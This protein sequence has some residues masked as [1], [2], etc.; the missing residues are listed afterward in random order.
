MSLTPGGEA[1][2]VLLIQ[3]GST[4][5]TAA[6]VAFSVPTPGAAS[7]NNGATDTFAPEVAIGPI[8]P[9]IQVSA[10]VVLSAAV[11]AFS[12]PTPSV[13]AVDGGNDGSITTT[14][15]TFAIGPA[16]PSITVDASVVLS[17][18]VVAFAAGTATVTGDAATGLPYTKGLKVRSVT[19]STVSPH[20]YLEVGV[21]TPRLTVRPGVSSTSMSVIS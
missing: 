1:L 20:P 19:V 17:A 21:S 8:T 2:Y 14:A 9:T 15:P 10:S 5:T 3:D 12:V 16:T 18:V 4:T 11:V 7:Q 6:V 13:A